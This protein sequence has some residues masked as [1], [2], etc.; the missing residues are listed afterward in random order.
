MEYPDLDSTVIATIVTRFKFL[1][2][3]KEAPLAD[4]HDSEEFKQ[5]TSC[6]SPQA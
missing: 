1:G 6:Q 3:V 2:E 5:L 4:N